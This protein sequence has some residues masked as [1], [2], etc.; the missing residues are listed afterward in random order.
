MKSPTFNTSS[1]KLLIAIFFCV[2]AFMF[3]Y[4]LLKETFLGGVLTP[5]GSHTITIIITSVLATVASFF[6]HKWAVSEAEIRIAATAFESQ[7][8][9]MITDVNCVI[10]RVN[11]A[12]SET[13]GYMADEVVGLKPNILKSGY[14]DAAFYQAMWESIERTGKW[15][16][17]IWERRKNGEIY[18]KWLNITAVKDNDGVVTHYI[19]SHIDISER[20]AAEEE[21]KNLAFYDLITNLPNRRLLF[22]HLEHTLATVNRTGR[23]GALLMIDLDHFKTLN[24]TL[25]HDIGDLLLKE[26]AQ[27]LKSCVRKGDTVSRFGGDEFVLIIENLSKQMTEAVAETEKITKNIIVT[28]RQPYQLQQNK[29]YSTP[30]IGATLFMDKQLTIDEILKQAD[31]AM[32]QAKKAG[33]CAMRFFDP[34]MQTIVNSRAALESDLREAL[35]KKQ[36]QLYYQ[37][38]LDSSYRPLGAEALIRWNHPEIGL[39]APFQFIPLAE[40]NGLIFPIGQWLLDTACAQLKTWQLDVKTRHFVL[41]INISAKEFHQVGF[42]TQVQSAI[43]RYKIDPK[44]LKLELTE[45]LLLD[46]IEEIIVTMHALKNIG[47]SISLDDFGTGYS[48][49]QYLKRLPLNQLKIDQSFVRDIETDESDKVIVKTIIAMAHNLGLEVIAEGVETE[50]QHQLLLTMGCTYFQGFLFSKPVPI[51]KFEELLTQD[52]LFKETEH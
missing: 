46:D 34:E 6:V 10:L 14:H 29:C 42:V 38:Q 3:S 48:S 32:Y 43:E 31:I 39:I 49:L 16:G 40:K 41:S 18:P 28:L 2:A 45:S 27:R 12:F 26:V 44:R 35:E 30:S 33:R 25:G 13:T 8:S 19:G 22:D 24:D 7:E 1:K 15:Q 23:K 11:Q 47:V 20:K 9:L 50:E 5:W 21:I 51:E 4:E 36:F 37:V 52:F 17:E